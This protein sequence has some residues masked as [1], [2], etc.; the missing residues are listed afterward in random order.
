MLRTFLATTALASLAAF[1]AYAQED[2]AAGEGAVIEEPMAPANAPTEETGDEPILPEA[3]E[4]AQDPAAPMPDADA[5][6]EEGTEPMQAQEATPPPAEG[7]AGDE[8]PLEEVYTE[9][10]VDDPL[11]RRPHRD[12]YPDP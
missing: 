12:R 8:P 10:D 7:L 6:G 9:V 11:R 4:T 1:G 3:D 5:A 2:P